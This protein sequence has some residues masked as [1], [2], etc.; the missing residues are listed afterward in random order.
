MPPN[1]QPARPIHPVIL[2]GGTGT[3]LWPL[4]RALY[5]KQLLPLTGSETMLQQTARRWAD[6]DAFAPPIIVCNEDHRFIV[7][8]QLREA[9]IAPERLV[10]E[11]EGRN[12]APAAAVAALLLAARQP[13]ALVLVAP[14]DHAVTDVAELR[15]VI[16]AAAEAAADGALVTFG[17]PPGSANPGYG[18]IHRGPSLGAGFEIAR[19]VEKP[20]AETARRYVDSGEYYWNSG[21]FLFTA[22]RYL[23][24][25]ERFKPAMVAACREAVEAGAED[26]DF[27][28]LGRDAFT[29]CEA[30]S[31]DYA[32][33]EKTAHAMVFPIE[34]GWSDVGSWAALWQIGDKDSAGNVAL[35]NAV[36]SDSTG[37]YLR[38]EGVLVAAL[39]VK[40][41][42]IVATGDAV[43]VAARE[44]AEEVK[45][46]VERLAAEGRSEPDS[47]AKVMRPWGSFEGIKEGP[48]FQVKHLRIKPGARLSL[49]YHERRADHCVVVGG[50]ARIRR[51]EETFTLTPDQSPYMPV[52]VAHSLENDGVEALEV[53]EVQTGDYLGEDDIVRLEDLYGRT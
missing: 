20:D 33:M 23:E 47:H 43:L 19:F 7:A 24:E 10:I 30:D 12:T 34:V 4:S 28:R 49:Q 50:E 5:P 29:R 11:P 45:T 2:S 9:D 26:L 25:L 44:R 27:F 40:D 1:P 46:L 37:S 18:Y 21:L 38:G 48:R 3:R 42:V 13:D 39:G 14:A 36:L 16:C 53:I 17:V 35:G 15:R 41:L 31:I 52:G 22:A 6:G 32:V 51:C 8:E